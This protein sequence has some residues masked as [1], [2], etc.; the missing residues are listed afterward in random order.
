MKAYFYL[1]IIIYPLF[2][3]LIIFLLHSAYGY[4]RE[5]G[6]SDV[7][8]EVSKTHNIS[9]I[10]SGAESR[11]MVMSQP[12]LVEEFYNNNLQQYVLK[13]HLK[14]EFRSAFTDS[15]VAYIVK[16]GNSWKYRFQFGGL[17]ESYLT[18]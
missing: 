18:N 2:T 9:I 7:I 14:T 10:H 3:G 5:K 6:P 17:H 11:E 1:K 13:C 16:K 15:P 8:I 12:E 4:S